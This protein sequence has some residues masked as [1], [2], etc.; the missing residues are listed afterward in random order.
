MKFQTIIAIFLTLSLLTACN[1]QAQ[2]EQELGNMYDKYNNQQEQ[3]EQLTLVYLLNFK[4]TWK[5][6]TEV[7]I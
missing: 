6:Y 1:N 3:A 2:L 5:R 7:P 4:N